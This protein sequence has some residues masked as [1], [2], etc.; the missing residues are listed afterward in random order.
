M[1]A[2]W[3]HGRMSSKASVQLS[4]SIG[5]GPR[6]VACPIHFICPPFRCRLC[7]SALL[8]MLG[9]TVQEVL[10]GVFP[11]WWM[12]SLLSVGKCGSDRPLGSSLL[13]LSPGTHVR[14]QQQLAAAATWLSS[15]EVRPVSWTDSLLQE[16]RLPPRHMMEPR[17][18]PT[19]PKVPLQVP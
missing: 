15:A 14:S 16:F 4:P 17:P 18:V 13:C 2:F 8:G 5:S 9:Q 1:P 11:V 6:E 19:Y 3:T 12:S 7:S 10:L